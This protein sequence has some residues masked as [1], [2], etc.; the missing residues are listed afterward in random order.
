MKVS[1]IVPVY[2][3]EK[4]LK[5]CLDSL[6]K[7]TLKDIEIIV[8]NDG[9]T[10]SSQL[11]IDEYKKKYPKKIISII[12]E[13]GGQGSARNLGIKYVTSK[14]IG[15]VDSDDYIALDMYE[16]LYNKAINENSDV[17]ICNNYVV[18][19]KKENNKIEENNYNNAYNII[20]NAF[21]GKMAVWNKIYKKELIV[22]NNIL[23]K[24]KIW[25]EDFAF[26]FKLLCNTKKISFIND[27]LY[28]YLLRPGSTMNN[29]NVS[30][31][32]EILD[33]FDDTIMYLNNN[34]IYEKYLEILEF[35]AIIHIYISTSVRVINANVLKYLK[36]QNLD[37]IKKY[38]KTN[39]KKY[40]KNKYIKTLSL[41]KKIIYLLLN[42]KFYMIINLIFKIKRR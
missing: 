19:L 31:N 26:T 24:E 28:M 17:V 35:N 1:V 23:F 10:D 34:N 27:Y 5:K 16:K 15:F 21:F 18:D 7:Q 30:R 4:Y 13:N 36:K 29:D 32:L 9:S 12:K 2:N 22:N 25:Y 8:V 41:N 20:E 37:E 14:Y 33:A 39:F 38:M 40:K 3:V 11:I 42:C 6:V